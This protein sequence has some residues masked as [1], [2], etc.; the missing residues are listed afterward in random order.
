MPVLVNDEHQRREDYSR[1][2]D[3]QDEG[4]LTTVSGRDAT[5]EL[6]WVE[7]RC[8]QASQMQRV[9]AP[10]VDTRKKSRLINAT[11]SNIPRTTEIEKNNYELNYIP[12][13]MK[14]HVQ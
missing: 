5:R 2:D 6:G 12:R 14:F 3:G 13:E 8:H 10:V 7:A 1:E 9:V 4:C 11:C